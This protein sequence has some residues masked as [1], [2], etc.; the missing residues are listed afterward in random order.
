MSG[1][2]RHMLQGGEHHTDGGKVLANRK[3][4]DDRGSECTR[5]TADSCC[6]SVVLL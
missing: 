4:A 6:S 5:T 1:Q 2:T 3:I